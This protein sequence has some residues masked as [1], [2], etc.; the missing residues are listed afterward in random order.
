MFVKAVYSV[1]ALLCI[2]IHLNHL[3]QDGF[4][5]CLSLLLPCGVF[6]SISPTVYKRYLARHRSR[7]D[8]QPDYRYCIPY[9]LPNS[10]PDRSFRRAGQAGV[11]RKLVH[12][13]CNNFMADTAGKKANLFSIS[14]ILFEIVPCFFYQNI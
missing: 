6:A 5:T 4:T 14:L 7:M 3:L 8:V 13:P 1:I 10:L 11:S 2:G 12:N 9:A